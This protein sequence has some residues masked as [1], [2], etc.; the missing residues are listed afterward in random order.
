MKGSGLPKPHLVALLLLAL[1][2]IVSAF[3]YDDVLSKAEKLAGSD[4]QA[5]SRAPEFLRTI[6]FATYQAIGFKPEARLWQGGR[7]R[8]QVAMVAQGAHY[9]HPVTINQIDSEGVKQVSFDRTDFTYP[10]P[11]LAK[12]IP[13][14]LGYAG[15]RLFFTPEKASAGEP[16]MV[17]AGNSYFRAVGKDQRFGLSARG[18]SV[19]TGLPS[20]E[21]FP[22][23]KEFWIERPAAGSE[24]LVVYGLLDGPSLTG[25]YRFV[26][27]PG[28]STRVDV[29]AELFF[30]ENIEQLGLAPLTSMFYFG[31]NSVPPRG[32]WRPQAHDSDGLLIHD[33]KSG[34]WLWRP[35]VN[36]AQLHLSFHQV[37]E[38][39]GFGLMQR[40]RA[41]HQF[42]DSEARY[43]LRPSAW[44]RPSESWGAGSV[45]L[46]EIPSGAETNDNIVAFWRPDEQIKA[47]GRKRF[48]YELK[49]GA[50]DIAGHPSGRAVH[51]FLGRESPGSG[52]EDL[53]AYRFI[54]DFR[55]RE[56]SSLKAGAPVV[57]EV[58]AN[59]G[60]EVVEHFV[61]YVPAS[62]VWRLSVLVRPPAGKALSL[63]GFLSLE[64][65]PLTETWT[66]SPGP[67]SGL[68]GIPD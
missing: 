41:F 55:G 53:G 52:P 38:L 33:G 45:V 28:E 21:E 29:T 67:S 5:P 39:A 1:P 32:E 12:R 8:F 20:G 23:F 36:P 57:S 44:V 48:E 34:E 65:K 46:V 61:E 15:F 40:D 49:F 2:S 10:N 18:I 11:E 30:R 43:D 25:A 16:F 59:E 42:Q 6:D 62:D 26:I 3:S 24:T 9:R 17:F 35:L 63:R 27:R 68:S 58:S 47:D 22:S 14:D 54:V 31:E 60:A 7:S 19:D 66:Y 50:P 37:E 13:A 51:T 4:Y 64:G 56:L